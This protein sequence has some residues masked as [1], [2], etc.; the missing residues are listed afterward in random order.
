M[1]ISGVHDA[2]NEARDIACVWVYKAFIN[3]SG[4]GVIT[5]V[6]CINCIMRCG[7]IHC[8]TFH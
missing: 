5:H 6:G 3:K 2:M 7:V 1:T 4:E 8:N